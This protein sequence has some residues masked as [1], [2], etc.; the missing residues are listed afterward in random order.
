MPEYI[1]SV[2]T[3]SG[4]YAAP[5][6]TLEEDES[7][8]LAVD[9]QEDPCWDGYEQIG[10]KDKDGKRVPN[11]V[12][13]A[14]AIDHVV[15]SYNS[16]FGMSRGIDKE[17]AYAVARKACSKY[18]YLENDDDLFSAILWELH[19]FADYATSGILDVE[20]D[21][22]N[23][24]EHLPYGHPDT[25]ASLT[26]AATWIAGAPELNNSGRE[27]LLQAFSDD[28][29]YVKTLHASTRVRAMVSSGSLT[30][31]TLSQIKNLS[32]RHSKVN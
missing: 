12:P 11:C 31:I 17:T 1:N 13:S 24:S 26:A 7:E 22:S 15:N 25:E 27:A 28:D 32:D 2:I 8:A 19:V 3:A 10:M 16:Q 9:K 18:S 14:S 30:D 4:G 20:E 29:D 5:V 6:E 21:F 23:Y